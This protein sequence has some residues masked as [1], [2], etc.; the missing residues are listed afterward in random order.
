MN[1]LYAL[2]FIMNGILSQSPNGNSTNAQFFSYEITDI[3]IGVLLIIFGIIVAL[4]GKRL[5]STLIFF[6]G[7]RFGFRLTIY[8]SRW[9]TENLIQSSV[10]DSDGMM[11]LF[12][13]IGVGVVFGVLGL[14][15][16]PIG[17]VMF[18]GFV[19][20]QLWEMIESHIKYD[21]ITL[22]NCILLAFVAIGIALVF[23]F[24]EDTKI[25]VMAFLGSTMFIQGVDIFSQ[26]G[27]YVYQQNTNIIYQFIIYIAGVALFSFGVW[28][29]YRLDNNTQSK[30]E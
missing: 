18:G 11:L 22:L 26:Q 1:K 13:A 3:I 20:L 4:Y 2:F 17:K 24:E 27:I 9:F 15:I 28:F 25:V 14:L 12:I 19:G 7:V 8:I 16:K 10:N 29:Q 21:N 6:I 5:Y 23:L 30:I